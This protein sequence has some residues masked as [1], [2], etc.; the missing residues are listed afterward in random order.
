MSY[1]PTYQPIVLTCVLEAKGR[2]WDD[3]GND[4]V[5]AT[6]SGKIRTLAIRHCVRRGLAEST[7]EIGEG[8]E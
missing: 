5:M 6:G 7:V 2:W 8:W 4:G 1:L 3:D